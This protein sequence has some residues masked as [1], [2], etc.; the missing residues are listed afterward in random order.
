MS[1]PIEWATCRCGAEFPAYNGRK[2]RSYCSNT[3]RPN[4]REHGFGSGRKTDPKLALRK[5]A[6][7]AIIAFHAD[8]RRARTGA[9][10]LALLLSAC[11]AP[12]YTPPP[13]VGYAPAYPPFER[14]IESRNLAMQPG[15]VELR[16]GDIAVC[17]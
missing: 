13:K 15:A 10:A 3:C 9:A 16:Q 4:G 8:H 2:K 1:K 14:Q 17:K 12:P 11:A 6:L 7:E 5:R